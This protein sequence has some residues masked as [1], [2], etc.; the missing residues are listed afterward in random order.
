MTDSAVDGIVLNKGVDAMESLKKTIPVRVEIAAI[1]R[2]AL[3]SGEYKSGDELS[4]TDIAARLGVSRTPVR[5]AFQTLE[6]EGL[7]ELRMNKGAIVLPIDSKYITDHYETR[8]LLESEAARRA[9]QN[10]MPDAPELLQRLEALWQHV[11]S[12]SSEEYEA[13]N[14]TVHSAIWTASQNERMYKLLCSLWNGPSVS[15]ISPKQDHYRKS[16][17]EHM[18]I[19]KAIIAGDSKNAGR[20][21]ARHIRRSLQNTLENFP[22]Q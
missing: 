14:L 8:E 10:G 9:A 18:A 22:I 5:E 15:I 20:E 2:K 17:A 12:V 1:L 21:M 13:L 16:T 7:I 19:L 3:F 11:D 4:L 6:S